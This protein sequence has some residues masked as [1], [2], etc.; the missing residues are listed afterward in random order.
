M[1]IGACP[2]ESEREGRAGVVRDVEF[3]Q[4]REAEN[5]PAGNERKALRCTV[6]S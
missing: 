4:V 2:F 6:K 3:A 5:M 1:Y